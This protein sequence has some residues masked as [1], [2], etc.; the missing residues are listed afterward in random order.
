MQMERLKQFKA[1]AI[2]KARRAGFPAYYI[3]DCIGEGVIRQMPDGRKERIV[4]QQ[5]KA[6]VEPVEKHSADLG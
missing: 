6:I 1:R 4:V 3:E 5:G 2:E